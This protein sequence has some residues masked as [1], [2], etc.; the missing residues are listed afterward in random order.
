MDTAV[1]LPPSITFCDKVCILFFGSPLHFSLKF[2]IIHITLSKDKPLETLSGYIFSDIY[3]NFLYEYE[4]N[5]KE[6][7]RMSIFIF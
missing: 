3:S 7:D 1:I 2:L 5:V 4:N 6:G